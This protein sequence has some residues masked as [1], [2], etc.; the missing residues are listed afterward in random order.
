MILKTV[1]TKMGNVKMNFR[2]A[3]FAAIALL[4]SAGFARAQGSRKDDIVF[5]AQ[6]RP[7]AGMVFL[8]LLPR[9]RRYSVK[10]A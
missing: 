8:A 5:N 3:A 7:M 10:C 2:C 1:L 6:G 4:V 9:A